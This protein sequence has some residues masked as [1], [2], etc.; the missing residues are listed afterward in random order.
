MS[1]LKIGIQKSGKLYNG[2]IDLLN[3]ADIKFDQT[4][5]QLIHLSKNFPLEIYFLRNSDIPKY[6]EDGVL[7]IA[8]IGNN[9]LLESGSDIKITE[10]LGFSKCRLSLAIPKVKLFSEHLKGTVS[11][12][13]FGAPIDFIVPN[14]IAFINSFFCQ[15]LASHQFP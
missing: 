8:I 4:K 7:D 2:S 6:V 10:K 14:S 1:K 12:K 15:D 3:R 11:V 9:Q 13:G 5:N